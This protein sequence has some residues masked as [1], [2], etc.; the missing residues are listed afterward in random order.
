MPSYSGIFTLPAQMQAKAA[1]NW[2]VPPPSIIGQAYG[3]GYYAGQIGVSSVPTHYIIIAPVSSGETTNQWKTAT[4]ATAGTTSTIDGPANTAAM[5]TAGAAAHPCANFC[6]SAVIGGFDDWYMPA[7]NE[8]EICYFS[9][10]PTTTANDTGFGGAGDNPNAVPA[11]GSN[12]T[13]GTPAQTPIVAFQFGATEA[14][15]DV[16]YWSSTQ[17]SA[18]TNFGRYQNFNTGFQ[19]NENKTVS[20]KVRA[21]RRVP[22]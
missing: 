19:Y 11:R 9:L 13:S 20:F 3:G 1:G 12:Y 18:G 21:I 5:I 22:V 15:T 10:K 17:S 6:N 2:P 7:E 14:F 8:L 4:T 16:R